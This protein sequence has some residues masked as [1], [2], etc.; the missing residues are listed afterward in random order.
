[1]ITVVETTPAAEP[2]AA[3]KRRGL[4]R[5]QRTST[6]ETLV[7]AGNGMVSHKLCENLLAREGAGRFRIVVFGEESRPAYDRVHLTQFFGGRTA[8]QLT[9]APREW[10]SDN[11]IELRLGDPVVRI[12]RE[13]KL[14]HAASGAEV[15]YDKLVLATGSRAFVPPIPG[16]DLPGVFVYRTL[17]DLEKIRVH[18]ANCRRAAVL[19]GGLLGLEAAKAL[20]DL[21]LQTWIVERGTTLL[22]RQLAPDGGDLLRAHVEKLGLHV[23]TR[24]EI[25]RIE[26][27]R[28]DRL[29]QFNTGECLRVQLVVVAAGIRP[30]D[31]LAA[32][33]GLTIAPRGG[34]QVND[35]LQTSDPSVYAIGECA[36]HNN[37]CY[38]LAAPGYKMADLLAD[39]LLGK[40]RRFTG[41]D[42]STR[43]KLAGIEVATLG[44]FQAEGSTLRWQSKEGFRQ[45]VLENGRLIG[46]TT[47]GPW[48]ESTRVQ[49]LIER[50]AR[51]WR[52]Q[53]ERFVRIGRIWRS[54]AALPVGQWPE[55]ALI[56]NCVGVRRGQLTAAC[57][58]GCATVEQLARRTGA[59][60]VCGSCK[61]LL[62][63]LVDAP[64]AS[65]RQSGLKTLAVACAAA[66]VLAL[67][68]FWMPP[69][70]FADS[71]QSG[72]HKIDV[73]WRE[74]VWKQTTGF[75]L[76]GLALVSLLLSLRK[77]IKRFTFGEFGHWR[78]VHATLGLLTL[79]VLVSHTG[80]R[81][82]QNFNFVLMTNFLALA[83][84]GALAGG[85]T[86][87][88]RRLQPAA[89]K[90]LRAF[91]TGTHI[92]M[93]WPLPVLIL[94]HVLMA[95][96]F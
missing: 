71:V 55:S 59:S 22:A 67:A 2:K 88:E 25:E 39:N 69:I 58:E 32:A 50:R 26:P 64:A 6:R 10:Y 85:V 17:D 31:E 65:V 92:A 61:P 33:C 24:R 37:V 81:L 20:H 66:L 5:R 77:R 45:L 60:T 27:L 79:V 90:R 95:Y 94:F 62:A 91:W 8:N 29:L 87:L 89:A 74:S 73:L 41:S 19:G 63:A 13:R 43:L 75:T 68:I 48:N 23:C 3:G 53:Q 38:G 7:I 40:R 42:Q 35:A 46:A 96:Y 49:E 78:A 56:C 12:D 15:P 9:L 34:V 36:S 21:G 1:M 44:E 84:V 82:G 52:W 47:I 57:A 28:E 16:H 18:A 51:V 14:V 4:F 76:V 93:A 72:W 11:G 54:E 83:L 86:V 80:F 30:R 70:A